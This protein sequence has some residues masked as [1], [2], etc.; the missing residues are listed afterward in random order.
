[1]EVDQGDFEENELI[2]EVL[3]AAGFSETFLPIVNEDNKQLLE[4]IKFL[5]K[6]K[7]EHESALEREKKEVL[8]VGELCKTADNEF[9]QNLKLLNAHK[10][11]YTAEYHLLKLGEHE[12]LRFKQMMKEVNKESKEML[13]KEESFKCKHSKKD[14]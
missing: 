6:S 7:L 1:M 12:S 13:E 9:D 11:Q 10:S 3:E 8:R 5:S 14:K 2:R 4:T